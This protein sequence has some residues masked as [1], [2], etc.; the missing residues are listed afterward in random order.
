ADDRGLECLAHLGLLGRHAHDATDEEALLVEQLGDQRPDRIGLAAHSVVD[1]HP[2]RASRDRGVRVG[3]L[4]QLRRLLELRIEVLLR[5]QSPSARQRPRVESGAHR[6]PHSC[7][8]TVVGSPP[9]L[10]A[11]CTDPVAPG[12]LDRIAATAAS[13]SSTTLSS[14]RVIPA[15]PSIPASS[16]GPPGSVIRTSAPSAPSG[17]S[18]T[19]TP[20]TARVAKPCLMSW[21]AIRRAWSTGIANP[22]PM[23]PDPPRPTEAMA[24]LIP[25]ISPF[26][27][28]S[29]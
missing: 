16:A 29:A 22:S 28:T 19:E 25:T 14:T 18:L 8:P 10:S 24:E 15:P 1:H 23:E 21:S 6:A 20:S 13:L 12:A 9:T 2:H 11:S 26:I 3:A 4:L 7:A 5:R 17:A 27:L